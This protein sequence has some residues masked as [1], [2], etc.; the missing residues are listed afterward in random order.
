MSEISAQNRILGII[1]LSKYNRPFH[2]MTY[3]QRKFAVA[4]IQS[5]ADIEEAIKRAKELCR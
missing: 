1:R 5:G 2:A 4:R 3:N